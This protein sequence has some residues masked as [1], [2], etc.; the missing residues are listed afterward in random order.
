MDGNFFIN[1]GSKPIRF[2][3]G[4]VSPSEPGRIENPA[5]GA[6]PKPDVA[7]NLAAAK[8]VRGLRPIDALKRLA[9]GLFGKKPAEPQDIS[10]GESPVGNER[11]DPAWFLRLQQRSKLDRFPAIY[12]RT[13]TPMGVRYEVSGVSREHPEGRGGHIA[14][15]DPIDKMM[16]NGIELAY[17]GKDGVVDN[18]SVFSFSPE[19]YQR[20][21]AQDYGEDLG[22]GMLTLL[23]RIG[24]GLKSDDDPREL[25]KKYAQEQ[26][27][28]F[29]QR[30]Y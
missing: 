29:K 12:L 17:V 9:G 24:A 27:D 4:E 15:L 13:E 16:N 2:F 7:K 23:G 20:K 21:Y 6:A 18:D 11:N 3:A 8:A 26:V 5:G 28:Y 14:I 30:R 22:A 10:T 25:L 19:Y 1:Q